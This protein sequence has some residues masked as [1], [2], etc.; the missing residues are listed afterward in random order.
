MSTSESGNSAA[1]PAAAAAAGPSS[2]GQA[3]E[4]E[5]QSGPRT[6]KFPSHQSHM[7]TLA[8]MCKEKSDYTDCVIQCTGGVEDGD[9]DGD[10]DDDEDHEENRLRA[11]RLV[12]G[13]VSPFM[14]LVFSEVPASLPEATILVPGVKKRVV[15]ALLDF[16]YTGE[17]KV[18]REDTA[19]LQLLIETLQIDPA[20]IS[21]ECL[22]GGDDDDSSSEEE[23]DAE[24][25]ESESE[26]KGVVGA[27]GKADD[28]GEVKGADDS[29]QE[30][31][32]HGDHTKAKKRKADDGGDEGPSQ[33]AA[34]DK[35]QPAESSS[36]SSN[37]VP[38][39]ATNTD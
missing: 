35:G 12:L 14:K 5:E 28:K 39:V 36:S 32:D 34:D 31:K 9:H 6:F 21:V 2:A 33:A 3:A 11:H 30:D 16:L 4:G 26:V 1:P 7:V 8:K 29:S 15:K 37:K 22:D 27:V 10:H 24:V 23:E 18:E 19:E 13:A 38:K 20:L 25:N 17:M